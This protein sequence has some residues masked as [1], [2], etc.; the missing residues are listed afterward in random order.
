MRTLQLPLLLSGSDRDRKKVVTSIIYHSVAIVGGF[1]MIYPILW[2]FASSLKGPSEIWANQASLI[3]RELSL[4]NYPNGW[5]GFAGITFTTFYLNSLFFAGIKT[6]ATVFSSAFIAYAFARLNFVGRKF[7]FAVMLITLMLP[8][9]VLMIPQYIF[10]NELG[11]INTYLPLV[12]P[13]FFGESAFFIFLIAQFIRGIP[14][15]L[16]EAAAID[17]C[18]K[19]GIFW[20]IIL[21][22]IKPALITTAIF[23]FYWTWD[24]FMGPLIYLNEPRLY[25]ISLALRSFADPTA[26]TDWGAL[27]AMLCASLVPVFAIFIFFQK[28]LVEGISTS[29]LKG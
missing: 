25:T 8:P 1:I 5:S 19:F 26:V 29:G 3:P 7:W 14:R 22:L 23:Q 17:G 4:E 20:R 10:F 11:W 16:D 15:E 24:E 13:P 12:I 28:Y 21:P 18:S 27:F 9:Q 2:M 6:L